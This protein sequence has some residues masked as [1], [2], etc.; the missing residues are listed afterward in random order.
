MND[1]LNVKL[2]DKSQMPVDELQWR[3]LWSAT[4]ASLREPGYLTWEPTLRRHEDGRSLVYVTLTQPG[5]STSS[6]GEIVA[7]GGSLTEPLLRSVSRSGLEGLPANWI[8]SMNK[9]SGEA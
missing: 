1:P 3:Q 7:P 5:G 8:E 2:P 6:V 4:W 9:A